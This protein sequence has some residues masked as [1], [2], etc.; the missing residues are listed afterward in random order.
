M[1][2]TKVK[3]FGH[4]SSVGWWWRWECPCCKVGA[5]VIPWY[6]AAAQL[7]RVRPA[8]ELA[9]WAASLHLI[10]AGHIRAGRA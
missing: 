9:M 10:E 8:S 6:N 7:G 1:T 2:G 5:W 4:R 3:I